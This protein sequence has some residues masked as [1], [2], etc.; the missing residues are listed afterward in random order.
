M[1]SYRMQI[2]ADTFLG[3]SVSDMADRLRPRDF[4][5]SEAQDVRFVFLRGLQNHAEDK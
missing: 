2:W 4:Q 3:A 5:A 1:Q